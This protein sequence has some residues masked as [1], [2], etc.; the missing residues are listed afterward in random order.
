MLDDSYD[1]MQRGGPLMWVI[2]SVSIVTVAFICERV[3]ALWGRLRLNVDQFV[4][5]LIELL[6]QQKMSRAVE[7]CHVEE[8]HPLAHVAKAGLM[9]AHGTEQEMRRSMEAALLG[10]YPDVVKR[11][12]Y[13]PVLANVATLFGLLG[14]VLGLIEAFK[15]VSEADAATKQEILA[16]GISM[17]MFTTAYGIAVAIPALIAAAIFQARETQMLAQL[18][19]KS[20]ELLNYLT[21]KRAS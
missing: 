2:F 17:A 12:H 19:A 20:A 8:R 16:R 9:V 5:H 13:L 18:E 3:Y 6:E 1:L 11:T 4:E 15:G 7:M 14:T 10:C 21:I